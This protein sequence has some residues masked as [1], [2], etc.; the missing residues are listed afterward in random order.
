MRLRGVLLTSAMAGMFATGCATAI[1]RVTAPTT[2]EPS[3][4]STGDRDPRPPATPIAPPVETCDASKAQTAIG[5]RASAALLERARVAAEAKTA[6]FLRPNEAVTLEYLGS[7]LNL[8]L[9]ERDVVRSVTC[10]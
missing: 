4:P 3:A 9:N 1:D 10:G 6:R 7:R 5:Q 8:G 2:I